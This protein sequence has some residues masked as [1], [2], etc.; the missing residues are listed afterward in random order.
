MIDSFRAVMYT[1]ND[2]QCQ[3]VMMLFSPRFECIPIETLQWAYAMTR[4]M[5]PE[6]LMVE[7]GQS[8]EDVLALVRCLREEEIGTSLI[9]TG[10]AERLGRAEKIA[11][12]QSGW[13]HCFIQPFHPRM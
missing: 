9:I 8:P 7:M 13:D 2:I 4:Q 3:E 5:R 11:G 6:V 10:M 12:F 1:P